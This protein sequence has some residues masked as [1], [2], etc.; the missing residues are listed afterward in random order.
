MQ[1]WIAA[2]AIWLASGFAVASFANSVTTPV[3][4]PPPNVSQAVSPHASPLVASGR[5]AFRSEQA[6]TARR[7]RHDHKGGSAFLPQL[8]QRNANQDLAAAIDS[9]PLAKCVHRFRDAP[10]GRCILIMSP[11]KCANSHNFCVRLYGPRVCMY[12]RAACSVISLGCV[13]CSRAHTPAYPCALT[14]ATLRTCYRVSRNFFKDADPQHDLSVNEVLAY[15]FQQI[16]TGS[17]ATKL[18]FVLLLCFPYV[19]ASATFYRSLSSESWFNAIYKT[20]CTLFRTPGSV[21]RETA[22]GPAIVLNVVFLYG[23]LFFAVFL[24]LITEDIKG[25]ISML[26]EGTT[27]VAQT[28]HTV[29]PAHCANAPRMLRRRR[30]G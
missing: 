29:R 26:R 4:E 13:C 18:G 24:G 7:L 17:T 19:L 5:C 21:N 3:P 11:G 30:A 8:P 10:Q 12:Q 9:L 6:F 1:S 14:S 16:I 2:I 25:Q 15:K 20:Y 22:A 27:P 28:G 23:F